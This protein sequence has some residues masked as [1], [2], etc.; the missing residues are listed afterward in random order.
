MQLKFK[1]ITWKNFLSTGNS[2]TTMQ[3]DTYDTTLI[4]GSNGSGKSTLLD[5]ITYVL[6]RSEEHTSELQSH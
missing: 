4:M 6:F 2:S 1:T 3:L 5:A